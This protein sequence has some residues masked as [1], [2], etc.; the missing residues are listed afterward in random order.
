M[1][2]DSAEECVRVF[3]LRLELPHTTAAGTS[4]IRHGG[5]A[6]KGPGALQRLPAGRGRWTRGLVFGGAVH[7]AEKESLANAQRV[8]SHPVS[9][10]VRSQRQRKKGSF[11]RRGRSTVT[12][13]IASPPPAAGSLLP[14]VQRWAGAPRGVVYD[15]HSAHSTPHVTVH[16]SESPADTP[17]ATVNT[18]FTLRPLLP[19]STFASATPAVLSQPCM[20]SRAHPQL[21]R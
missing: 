2:A 17:A 19:P 7:A 14:A 5:S 1:L 18:S 21:A 8:S 6:S 15:A 20:E 3:Q 10:P 12:P 16:A 13:L 4:L 9:I 11:H